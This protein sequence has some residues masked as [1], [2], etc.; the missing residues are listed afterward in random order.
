MFASAAAKLRTYVAVS[1]DETCTQLVR[2]AAKNRTGSPTVT[3]NASQINIPCHVRGR[4]RDPNENDQ[5]GVTTALKRF[6]V[7]VPYTTVVSV[8]NRWAVNN[9]PKTTVTTGANSV[10]QTVGAIGI[11]V[12]KS[13]VWF[14]TAQ[15]LAQ[16]VAVNGFVLTLATS[17]STTTNEVAQLAFIYEI[18]AHDSGKSYNTKIITDCYAVDDATA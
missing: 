1:W 15:V 16:V 14:A 2:V 5:A 8:K 18:E 3:Y 10:N 9:G 17:V 12:P 6:Q 13:W 11:I 7:I 4:I